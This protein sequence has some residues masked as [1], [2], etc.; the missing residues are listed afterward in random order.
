MLSGELFAYLFFLYNGAGVKESLHR[1]LAK[2]IAALV[3]PRLI[4]LRH[5]DIEILLQFA[6]RRIDLLAEGDAVEL[7]EHGLVKPLDDAIIRYVIRGAFLVWLCF[8]KNSVMV[9][10]SGTQDAGSTKVRAGRR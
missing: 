3:R 8:S 1:P 10:P 5:P 6:D 2:T 4:I 7:I 9:S